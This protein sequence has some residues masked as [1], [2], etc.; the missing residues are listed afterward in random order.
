[1]F[2]IAIGDAFDANGV[3]WHIVEVKTL[4]GSEYDS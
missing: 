3:E 1:M 2:V 4:Q